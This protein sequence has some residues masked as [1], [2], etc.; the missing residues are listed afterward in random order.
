MYAYAQADIAVKKLGNVK[1]IGL[2]NYQGTLVGNSDSIPLKLA[3]AYEAL[4]MKVQEYLMTSETNS[5]LFEAYR[6]YCEVYEK[7]TGA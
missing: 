1:A 4:V 7:Y 6:V 3:A 2:I 5:G